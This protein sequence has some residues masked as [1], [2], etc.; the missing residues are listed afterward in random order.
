MDGSARMWISEIPA[1][2]PDAREVILDLDQTSADP[3]ERMACMLLNRGH[4]GEAGVFYLLPEDLSARYERTGNRLTVSLL[5]RRD[6][7][8]QDLASRPA[9]WRAH[10]DLLP[11]D[12]LHDGRVVLVRRE[13]VTDFVPAER[14][15]FQQPVVLIDHS[16]EHGDGPVALTELMSLFA[17]QE[18]GVAVVAAPKAPAA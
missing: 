3:A 18:A 6:V 14:D 15:G 17:R 16:V 10:L 13:T 9:A 11:R 8:A 2:D 4:E 5:A 1:L 7:L 12:P